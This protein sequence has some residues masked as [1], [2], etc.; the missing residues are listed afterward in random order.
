MDTLT[1][2][3]LERSLDANETGS[4]SV[5]TTMKITNGP[6][7]NGIRNARNE[8]AEKASSSGARQEKSRVGGAD[9]VELS[10][11]LREVEKLAG[12][13]ASLPPGDT[14]KIESIKSRIA[15]GS[16]HVSGYAVAEKMLRSMGLLK[17]ESE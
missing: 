4:G 12:V 16:Y 9:R 3:T 14:E 10:G 11:G 17:G 1:P 15:D 13:V 6:L 2:K 5:G 8:A 7:N